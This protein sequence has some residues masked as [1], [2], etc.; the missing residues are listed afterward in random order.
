[1]RELTTSFAGIKV[2]PHHKNEA[3][4]PEIPIE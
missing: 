2:M 4:G 1:M 3:E